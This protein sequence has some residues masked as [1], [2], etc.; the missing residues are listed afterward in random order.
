MRTS[1]SPPIVAV[2]AY[3]P[4]PYRVELFDEITK[5]GQVRLK[6]LYL[7]RHEPGR[8]WKETRFAHDAVFLNEQAVSQVS[9]DL[10]VISYH[11]DPVAAAIWS[12]WR[13]SAKPWV[14]WGERPGAH[15]RGWLGRLARRWRLRHLW[16]SPVPVWAIGSWAAAA[17]RDELGAGRQIENMPYFSDLGRFAAAARS[18]RAVAGKRRLLFCGSLIKRKGVDVLLNAFSRVSARHPGLTLTLAG[19]GELE[20]LARQT[21]GV[22][23]LGFTPW[24]ELPSLY[25]GHDILVVPSRYDGW[26]MVVPEGLAAGMPVLATDQMGAARDLVLHDANGWVA[27]A[28]SL[29]S[30]A[31]CLEKAAALDDASLAIM[32][33]RASSSVDSHQLAD[34]A[35]AFERLSLKALTASKLA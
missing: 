7:H 2:I 18:R 22:S 29:E 16:K 27:S 25:S 24:E 10:M 23:V 19:A 33:A 1:H 32:A 20:P 26:G 28:G 15:H 13:D 14:F 35:D 11:A 3:S 34:G 6:A 9:A 30:L 21:S 8:L 4:A 5:R 12:A 31:A 17:Y